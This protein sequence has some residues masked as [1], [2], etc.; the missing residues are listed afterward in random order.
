MEQA[1]IPYIAHESMM[2]RLERITHRQWIVILVL[3]LALVASNVG[4]IVYES[5]WETYD[6]VTVTQDANTYTL[7]MMEALPVILLMKNTV[8][9]AMYVFTRS[10]K[11]L[12]SEEIEE[13]NAEFFERW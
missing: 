5:Q 12:T 10:L 7:I 9:L 1:S 2:A 11:M 13:L 6:E 3:I 8:C 4:W